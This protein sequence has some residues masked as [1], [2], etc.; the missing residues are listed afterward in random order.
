MT[1]TIE[2]LTARVRELEEE[3]ARLKFAL[4]DTEAL[5][6]G[7]SERLAASQAYA[8][9]LRVAIDRVRSGAA[10]LGLDRIF[11]IATEALA[12]PHD[13]SALGA[14]VAKK[15]KEK[16]DVL[17][18]RMEHC[19][20][21]DHVKIQCELD[22]ITEQRD[23]AVEAI[24]NIFHYIDDKNEMRLLDEHVSDDDEANSAVEYNEQ[25]DGAVAQLRSVVSAIKESEGK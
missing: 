11:D 25:L 13:T 5:E 2:Q 15:V 14:Y 19:Y 21:I 20:S 8:E 22:K 24:E 4:A 17:H 18:Y 7:T 3:N 23:L 16:T 6:L 12:L 9:Q 10:A 1:Q